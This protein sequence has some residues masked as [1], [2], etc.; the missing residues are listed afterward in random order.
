VINIGIFL[1]NWIGDV[2][3]ATPTLRTLRTH[4]GRNARLVGIFRPYVADVLAGTCW[5]DDCIHYDRRSPA[6]E[7]KGWPFIQRLRRQHL[8]TVFLLTNSLRSALFAWASGASQRIGYVRYGRGPLLTERLYPPRHRN[9]FAPVSA[10]DYYLQLAQVVG[11]SCESRQLE[12]ATQPTHE[13]Q[14]DHV[15]QKHELSANDPVVVFSAGAAHGNAKRWSAEQFAELARRIADELAARVLI[16]CGPDDR[17]NANAIQRMSGSERVISLAGEPLSV[18]L[19]KAIVRRSQL[20]I[21][22]DSGPRHFAAAF[23]VPSIVLFGPT[24]PRWSENYHIQELHLK[25]NVPCGPCG[26]RQCPLAHHRC[27][28]ELTVEQV[29][30]A[31]V[32]KLRTRPAQVAA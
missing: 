32:E 25:K 10:V 20:L 1:P 22:N 12:L 24:D 4:Y 6:A 15:W 5:L 14:A 13:S 11:A 9:K 23:C 18:G 27:M 21:T 31:A 16:I 26:Q 29:F 3:M 7:L 28:R 8:D 30:R 17:Q 2:V 19:S